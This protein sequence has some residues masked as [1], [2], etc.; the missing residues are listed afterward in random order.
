VFPAQFSNMQ[1]NFYII[2]V[3]INSSQNVVAILD[4]GMSGMNLPKKYITKSDYKLSIP[5][6][7]ITITVKN[8]IAS[9]GLPFVIIGRD[10]LE[11]FK[12]IY[13]SKSKVGFMM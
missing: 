11:Q 1:M 13:L 8:S 2:N 7:D 6:T 10:V 5:S 12:G 4:N 3:T 9:S